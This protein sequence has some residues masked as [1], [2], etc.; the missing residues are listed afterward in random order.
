MPSARLYLRADAG[1]HAVMDTSIPLQ[2]I[3]QASRARLETLTLLGKG[4][5]PDDFSLQVSNA[6]VRMR[7]VGEQ[8]LGGGG[9]RGAVAP[10]RERLDVILRLVPD[11]LP[12]QQNDQVV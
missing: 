4:H 10:R 9:G 6:R 12:C 7:K 3:T 8:P 11:R 1:S 2:M 5:M